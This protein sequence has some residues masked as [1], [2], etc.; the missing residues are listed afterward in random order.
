MDTS[1]LVHRFFFHGL[2]PNAQIFNRSLTYFSPGRSSRRY[3]RPLGGS[4]AQPRGRGHPF[5]GPLVA[6]R[7]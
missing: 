1:Q 5:L 4:Q 6:A 3:F 7:R 2:L